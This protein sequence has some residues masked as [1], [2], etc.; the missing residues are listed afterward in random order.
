MV[1]VVAPTAEFVTTVGLLQVG[2]GPQVTLATHP[3]LFTEVSLMN[4][5][6]KQPSALEE[7]NGPGILAPVKLPQYEPGKAAIG[8][9]P[10]TFALAICGAAMVFPS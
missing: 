9:K 2:G 7:V 8:P 10:P 6:V 4:R 3:G 5:N 1:A